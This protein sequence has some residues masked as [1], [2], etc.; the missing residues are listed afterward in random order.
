M[1]FRSET[2]LIVSSMLMVSVVPIRIMCL[3]KCV[4]YKEGRTSKEHIAIRLRAP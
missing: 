4:Y 3:E 2:A 1:P